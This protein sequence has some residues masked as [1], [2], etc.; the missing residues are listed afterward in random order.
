M[1]EDIE[2]SAAETDCGRTGITFTGIVPMHMQTQLQ[3]K[4][5]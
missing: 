5:Q 4:F 1:L 2:D 3:A